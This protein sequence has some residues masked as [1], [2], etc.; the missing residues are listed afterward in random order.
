MAVVP[1]RDVE[2]MGPPRVSVCIANFNGEAMLADC[3]E[4]VLAQDTDAIIEILVHD[5]ASTDASLDLL[6]HRYPEVRVIASA[7]NVGFCVANNRMV[8]SAKGAFVLLLNNDAA[9][10]SDAIGQLLDEAAQ[11]GE[12]GI[13]T[14]PQYD[15]ISETLVDRG[16]LLDP[17]YNP[18]PNLDPGRHDVAYVIG[19]C[20][21][22][23]R[24]LWMGLG[25]FPEWFGSIAEDIYL[26]GA[27]RLRDVPV[28]CLRTSGYRHRQG[29]SF[30]GNRV[31]AGALRTT[32]KRRRLSEVNKT[33]ALMIL[34]PGFVVWPLL[35]LHLG[36]LTL[37]GALL[38]VVRRDTALWQGVYAKAVS[39]PF[40]EARHL[41][42][43]RRRLQSS[44][45]ISMRRWY[46]VVT[47]QLRKIAVL[48]RY[49]LPDVR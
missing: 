32:L 48:A 16:C 38:S 45:T 33:R 10:C 7:T 6:R 29:A 41:L 22:M 31:N 21:F 15:W 8:A 3:I 46:S 47:W 18:V 39:A 5:D 37:E 11:L 2:A 23:P 9:L 36:A 14:L 40:R 35:I 25:G 19:A 26:C 28:R 20:M 42:G 43:H 44:R 27:A 13:L 49:G 4:S 12:P 1:D 30:G 17:F 24:T 34:T